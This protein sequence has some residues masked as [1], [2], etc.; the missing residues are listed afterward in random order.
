M[1]PRSPEKLR[2]VTLN[3]FEKD[4]AAMERRYGHGWSERVREL[5]RKHLLRKDNPP[6]QMTEDGRVEYLK[7][8]DENE[9]YGFDDEY[10]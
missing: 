4:C 2:K 6:M 9:S 10:P 1:P 7:V 3:L 5:V 8:P